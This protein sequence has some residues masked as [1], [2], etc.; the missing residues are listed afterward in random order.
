MFCFLENFCCL[1]FFGTLFS[2][3]PYFTKQSP[4]N[5][6]QIFLF[7]K[8]KMLQRCG[9]YNKSFIC[10]QSDLLNGSQRAKKTLDWGSGL[11]ETTLTG[12]LDQKL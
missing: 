11:L 3:K 12:Q 2:E 5:Y 9:F 4:K 1:S 7:I 10:G 6:Q 8:S